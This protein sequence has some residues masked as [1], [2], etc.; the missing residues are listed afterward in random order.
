MPDLYIA[1]FDGSH[2]SRAAV[3]FAERL[4]G[5]TG[6]DTIAATV[7][8][9]D[10]AR[11]ASLLASLG[12][13]PVRCEPVAASSPAAGL[14]RLAAERGAALLVVGRAGAGSVAE[15][16]LHDAPCAVVVVPS[17]YAADG[18]RT[19]IVALRGRDDPGVAVRAAQ[20]LAVGLRA[21][22][23]TDQRTLAPAA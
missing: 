11:A 19:V 1:G 16:L 12:D 5:S 7:Y 21:R 18:R 2:A 13:G 3:R 6:A 15:Q 17:A 23:V 9:H 14:R 4:A 20:D 8:A 22:L 10:P